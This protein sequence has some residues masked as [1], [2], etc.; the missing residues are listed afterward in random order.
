MVIKKY[1]RCDFCFIEAGIP[2]ECA[3][4]FDIYSTRF[5]RDPEKSYAN[6]IYM[7][8]EESGE[9]SVKGLEE[10]RAVMLVKPLPWR[11]PRFTRI[12]HHLDRKAARKKSKQSLQQTLPRVEGPPSSRRK[13]VVHGLPGSL[14]EPTQ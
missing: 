5:E 13:P 4:D 6:F 1:N 7:S 10:K 2:K 12:L 3:N 9:E 8:S 14:F 11:S